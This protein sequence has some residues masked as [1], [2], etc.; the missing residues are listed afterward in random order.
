VDIVGGINS[1]PVVDLALIIGLGLFFFLGVLQGAIRR[2]IGI[3]SIM[4]AF[5]LAANMRDTVGGMLTQNWTQFDVGY[6]HLLAFVIVFVV[7]AVAFMIVTQGLY[8]RTDISADH[9]IIDDVVGGLLGLVQGLIIL[10][11]IVTILGSYPLPPARPG[12]VDQL[13]AVQDMILNQSHIAAA[14]KSGIVPAFVHILGVLLPADLVS[15]FP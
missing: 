9:P 11:I 3:G 1:A 8:K 7:A 14:I 2:L 4:V 5:L 12:D 15:I 13:R 10:T 6:N